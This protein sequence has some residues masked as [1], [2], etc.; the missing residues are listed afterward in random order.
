MLGYAGGPRREI[1]DADWCLRGELDEVRPSFLK[2]A[3]RCFPGTVS[4][5]VM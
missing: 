3:A 4:D 5:S 2:G 1:R